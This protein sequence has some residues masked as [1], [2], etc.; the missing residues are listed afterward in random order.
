MV[1]SMY[2]ITTAIEVCLVA[3]PFRST[4]RCNALMK[5]SSIEEF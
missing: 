3:T 2:I 5:K 1:R 4:A